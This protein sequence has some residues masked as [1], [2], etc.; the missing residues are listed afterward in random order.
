M[1]MMIMINLAYIKRARDRQLQVMPLHRNPCGR[2][3]GLGRGSC[4]CGSAQVVFLTFVIFTSFFQ[5]FV[6]CLDLSLT[7][8]FC[9][10][11][12]FQ[13]QLLFGLALTTES[14]SV[15][16]KG[17]GAPTRKGG[18]LSSLC[19]RYVERQAVETQF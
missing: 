2:C 6:I 12:D 7:S 15:V 4:C 1:M 10:I 8:T 13:P 3:R 16:P 14:G 18:A 17:G 11:C 19:F 5:H 9:H